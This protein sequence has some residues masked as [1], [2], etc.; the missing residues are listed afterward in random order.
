[1]GL[2]RIDPPNGDAAKD[3]QTIGTDAH[4]HTG[5]FM[6]FAMDTIDATS[7]PDSIAG[8]KA[9]CGTTCPVEVS[10]HIAGALDFGSLGETDQ[11]LEIKSTLALQSVDE[12]T[13]AGWIRLTTLAVEG[14]PS[15]KP[16]STG[17]ADTWQLCINTSGSVSFI[18]YSAGGS[19]RDLHTD[20]VGDARFDVSPRRDRVRRRDEDCT[21]MASAIQGAGT[22]PLADDS[23]VIIQG[24]DVDSGAFIAPLDGDIDDMSFFTYALTPAEVAALAAQ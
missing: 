15:S 5:P 16:Y 19:S 9:T 4:P 11:R 14:C 2:D 20:R 21:G 24:N 6:H 22:T 3:S 8:A 13:V 10:G 23:D 1:M 12:F 7:T 17:F 18:T